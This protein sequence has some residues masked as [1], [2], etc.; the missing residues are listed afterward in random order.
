LTLVK[1]A[2]ARLCTLRNLRVVEI[3]SF[4]EGAHMVRR[5]LRIGLSGALLFMFAGLFQAC[6]SQD[7]TGPVANASALTPSADV[8]C[9]WING[10]IIC[11]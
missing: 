5:S 4:S 2:N 1:I 11:D 9:V 7:P 10:Q 8:T 3:T 6:S